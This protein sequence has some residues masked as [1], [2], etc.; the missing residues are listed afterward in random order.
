M[1]QGR[2]V[3]D[4]LVAE[5]VKDRLGMHDWRFG[6]VLDG[7]PR[8]GP[9]AEFF[10]ENFDID[11]VIAFELAE[12]AAIE[13]MQSRRLCSGCGLDYNLIQLRPKVVEVCDNCGGRLVPR[14][15]DTPQAIRSRLA[16]YREKTA[17][18]LTLLQEKELIVSVD[19]TPSPD[20]VQAEMRKRLGLVEAAT[21]E[22]VP[23]GV[24]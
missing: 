22:P 24:S 17:P 11:A 19:A 14:D 13:R 6:F 10:L 23:A 12:Q 2:L 5:V 20:V 1:S 15:D 16:D 3:P 8:N 18:I 4:E 21:E 9:Q 7:F